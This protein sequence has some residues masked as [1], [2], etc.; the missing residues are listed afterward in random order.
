MQYE[1][2]DAAATKTITYPDGQPYHYEY[3][4]NGSPKK[5]YQTGRVIAQRSVFIDPGDGL[6]T[7]ELLLEN[8]SMSRRTKRDDSDRL[9][10]LLSETVSPQ[11]PIMERNLNYYTNGKIQQII[12]VETDR[13]S[14]YG[15]DSLMRLSEWS[16]SQ[17]QQ[18]ETYSFLNGGTPNPKLQSVVGTMTDLSFS[19]GDSDFPWA[20]TQIDDNQAQTTK[21]LSYDEDGIVQLQSVNGYNTTHTY[22]AQGLVKQVR[23]G[24]TSRRNWH[25]DHN[26]AVATTE[27]IYLCRSATSIRVS[28]H[29]QVA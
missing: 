26:G 11:T 4:Q 15:Y 1:Y 18:F 22:N 21:T 23:S 13:T 19:Y 12:D 29:I 20:V 8:G 2:N 7:T 25:Y 16:D 5:L 14:N 10:S 6:E 28:S 17:Y 27:R 9:L 3:F 24:Y